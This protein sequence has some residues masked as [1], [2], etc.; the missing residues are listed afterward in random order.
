MFCSKISKQSQSLE[1]YL[2]GLE[3]GSRLAANPDC[4]EPEARNKDRSS[5][6]VWCGNSLFQSKTTFQRNATC[7]RRLPG[8]ISQTQMFGISDVFQHHMWKHRQGK[9]E[10]SVIPPSPPVHLGQG[11]SP[12]ATL[13]VR[14]GSPTHQYCKVFGI[15]LCCLLSSGSRWLW[16][17]P[18]TWRTSPW[19]YRRASCSWKAVSPAQFSIL[20]RRHV[21]PPPLPHHLH[22][23]L[24]PI[25]QCS[26]HWRLAQEPPPQD[27]PFIQHVTFPRG[28]LPCLSLLWPFTLEEKGESAFSCKYGFF[29]LDEHLPLAH[30][31]YPKWGEDDEQLHSEKEVKSEKIANS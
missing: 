7:S 28:A 16:L 4:C 17:A 6:A 15:P 26:L 18:W 12:F 31:A 14:K 11:T 21:F 10:W 27:F 9:G 25:P 1:M 3:D 20:Q 19:M 24:Q 2:R 13:D 5:K 30:V 23:Q 8:I 22:L 29:S